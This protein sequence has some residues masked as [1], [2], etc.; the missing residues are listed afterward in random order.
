MKKVNVALRIL[1]M[2]ADIIIVMLPVQFMMMGVFGVSMRQA[3][4]FFQ[5]LLAIYSTL[6]TE[7]RGATLGKI[8]AK[9]TVADVA[10]MKPAMMYVGLRELTK[11]MYFVPWFGWML[12]VVSVLMAVVRK[13]GRALHDIVGNTRVVYTN[14]FMEQQKKDEDK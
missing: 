11:S 2:I 3:E 10:G 12:C 4:F 14:D 5:I 13:D 7:Y 1:G 9:T 6:L 8:F